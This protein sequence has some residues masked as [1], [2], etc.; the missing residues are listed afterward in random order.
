MRT[1]DKVT[2][3][4]IGLVPF[5]WLFG[6]LNQRLIFL[7][8]LMF[9]LI[10]DIIDGYVAKKTDGGTKSGAMFDLYTDYFTSL[11]VIIILFLMVPEI[12]LNNRFLILILGVLGIIPFILSYIKFKKLPEYHLISKV[13][14]AIFGYSFLVY[15][16]FLGYNN[17]LFYIFTISLVITFLEMTLLIIKGKMNEHIKSVFEIW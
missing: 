14:S 16:L 2:L 17:L 12:F 11:S 13:V 6:I 10:G 5:I 8:L 15:T 1:A 7:F 3:F 9:N 4:R